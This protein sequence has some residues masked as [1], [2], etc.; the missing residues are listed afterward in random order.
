MNGDEK[1]SPRSRISSYHLAFFL[2]LSMSHT[3]IYCKIIRAY[4]VAHG[5][6]KNS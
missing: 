1:S 5:E 3:T 2:P 6:I 4:I